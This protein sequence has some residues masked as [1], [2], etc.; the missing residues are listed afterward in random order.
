[1]I[2]NIRYRIFVYADEDEEKLINALH[3]LL[4]TAEVNR[5]IA[6][7]FDEKPITILS[8]RIDKNRDIKNF[9]EKLTN[10]PQFDKNSFIDNLSRKMDDNGNL[11]LRFSKE[12]AYEDELKIIDSGDS[13]HLKLKI[14]AFPAKKKIAIDVIK[15]NL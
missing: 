11:F 1:M 13:I 6:E 7:G 2:H 14:A 3:N 5:E 9:V 4:P 15:N 8:G 10:T 12:Y